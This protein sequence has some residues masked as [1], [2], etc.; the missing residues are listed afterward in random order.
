MCNHPE[1]WNNRPLLYT[2]P[3]PLSPFPFPSLEI[4]CW[5]TYFA[6]ESVPYGLITVRNAQLQPHVPWTHSPFEGGSQ[7]FIYL[8][9]LLIYTSFGA[10]FSTESN[11]HDRNLSSL[12]NTRH[13][14]AEL[15]G[16]RIRRN[17]LQLKQKRRRNASWVMSF[18]KE[19]G[20][21][22]KLQNIK[23]SWNDMNVF[24]WD[25]CP[26]NMLED[27]NQKWFRKKTLARKL[28]LRY[29]SFQK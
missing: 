21:C 9:A 23:W 14:R 7:I 3:P 19:Y 17:W 8:L 15:R 4:P 18:C 24:E 13:R 26:F 12:H 25:C 28:N 2:T 11:V 27:C 20:F 1:I 16:R 29:K 5:H 10:H 6:A 22:V